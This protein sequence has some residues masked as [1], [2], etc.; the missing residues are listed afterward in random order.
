MSH[1]DWVLPKLGLD[2]QPIT[3]SLWHVKRGSHVLEGDAVLEILAGSVTVDLP[4]PVSGVVIKKLV[5]EEDRITAGQRLAVIE[6]DAE[7]P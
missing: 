6:V 3:A 7:E 5:H 1:Y 4:A 2:D